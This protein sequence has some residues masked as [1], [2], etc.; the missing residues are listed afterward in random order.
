MISKS[1]RRKIIAFGSLLMVVLSPS[2][3]AAQDKLI[4]FA[5]AS[6]ADAASEVSA[7]YE[8][9]KGIR[10]TAS[11]ASSSVL[12]KQ[13][14]NGAPAD[15]FIS[16]DK[17][18]MDYLQEKGKLAAGSRGDLL[19]NQLVLIAPKGK[20]FSINAEKGVDIAKAFIGKIC[21]GEV[22]AVPAGIYAKQSLIYLGWWDAI[23][24]RLVGAQD[25]RAALMLVERGEC[26][27]GIV[28]ATDARASSKVD[29]VTTFPDESHEPIVYPVS[30][31]AGTGKEAADFVEFLASPAASAIFSRHGFSVIRR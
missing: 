29:V 12:A 8:K 6:L 30:A 27:A 31:V 9:E 22:E 23:K 28:Y 15:V 19:G 25:V 13:I 26:G 24:S 2:W 4:L 10:V 11:F 14:E 3:A 1:A 18:W 7:Q 21:T 16:A 5:A 20:V 17:K